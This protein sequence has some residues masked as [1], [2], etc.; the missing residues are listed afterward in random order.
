M[1]GWDLLTYRYY[2]SEGIPAPACFSPRSGEHDE[3]PIRASD[4]YLR[5]AVHVRTRAH[6]LERPGHLPYAVSR[7]E[8]ASDQSSSS[9]SWRRD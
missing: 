9:R 3:T 8:P 6:C 1:I 2:K 4:P 5:V 7:G